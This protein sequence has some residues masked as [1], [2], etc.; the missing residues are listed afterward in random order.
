MSGPE[1]S[2][3]TEELNQLHADFCHALADTRRLQILYALEGGD[4][5]V[6]EIAALLNI[7]QPSTSRHLKLL[8]ERGLVSATREGVSVRYALADERLID[9]IDLLRCIMRDRLAHQASL[10]G[11]E[12]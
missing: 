12:S 10:A 4:R 8:R 5:S 2:D 7:T 1:E 9:A 11:I 3:L 6:N